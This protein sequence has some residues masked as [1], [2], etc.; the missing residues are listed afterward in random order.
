M[1]L[2]VAWREATKPT[3]REW[4]RKLAKKVVFTALGSPPVLAG[5]L[6]ALREAGALTILNL[7]RVG[8]PDDSTY[9]PLAPHLLDHLLGFV[10]RHFDVVTFASLSHSAEG[11]RPKL[12]LSFDDGYADFAAHAAPLLDRYGVAANL[13]IIPECIESGV[14]PLN[15]VVQDFVGRAPRE[16]LH[17][18]EVPGFAVRPERMSRNAY[19]HRLGTFIAGLP[20]AHQRAL[21]DTLMAQM[22]RLEG[23]SPTPMLTLDQLRA[24]ATRHEL[25]VHS[26]SHASMGLEGDDYLRD[27]VK[28]CRQWF[29]AQLDQDVAVY[30]FPNGS[31]RR[32]QLDIVHDAGVRHILLVDEDYSSPEATTHKRFTFHAY[33]RA[34]VRYRATGAFRRP[35]R[36]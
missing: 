29:A 22:E 13:N 36:A 34:E 8:P 35:Q 16:A 28:R 1:C 12:I 26:F 15:V 20:V 3:M 31:Y 11:E 14:P 25:G 23:F 33:S 24:L 2:A 9:P 4:A 30:A 7:H 17:R 18:L 10:T 21:A 32:D 27:D 5:K 6:R 19:G